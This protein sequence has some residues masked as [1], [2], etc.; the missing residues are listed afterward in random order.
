VRGTGSTDFEVK[1]AFVPR[2]REVHVLKGKMQVDCP[3]ARFPNF[4]LLAAG[5]AA[6]AVGIARRAVDEAIVVAQDKRPA[7]QR[8]RLAEYEPAQLDIAHA[9]ARL[10][11]A[12]AFVHEQVGTAWETVVRGDR[13]GTEQRART[14]LACHFA[15][16]EAAAA[17]DL[18]YGL[19]GGSSV[20]AS[21]PLQRCFR[22]V[23]TATQ[24]LMLG[25]R[26]AVTYARLRFG[27][28]AESAML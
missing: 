5:L 2:G 24:H 1:G 4:N 27:L 25:D 14:R 10:R 19:A 28:E 11:S 6:V 26:N 3:L 18:A 9:E 20:L 15:A 21:S 22:D 23:H 16:R 7:M 17:T 12:R 8:Q 13:V